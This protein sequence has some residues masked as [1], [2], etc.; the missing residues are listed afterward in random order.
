MESKYFENPNSN[1]KENYILNDI[2]KDIIKIKY[3]FLDEIIRKNKDPNKLMSQVY[4]ICLCFLLQKLDITY[5]KNMISIIYLFLLENISEKDAFS[6]I[7]N[8][9][10]SNNS[11]SKLYLWEERFV[12][13]IEIFFEEQFSENIPRL[14]QYF[15]KLGITCNLYLYDW[16]EGLFTQTLNIK[17][18]SVIFELYLIYG[19]YILIQTSITILKIL[20]EELLD[21]T[22]DEIFKELKRMPF[23]IS[24]MDFFDVFRNYNSIKEK[25]RNNNAANEF[26][27]QSAILFEPE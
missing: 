23:N 4:S 17:I 8:L 1:L 27:V 14:K 26:A 15:Q 2:I 11:L 18:A 6:N 7:Y 22:I 16:I 20:E 9:I 21:L 24:F 10:C 3:L 12:K 13:I 5:N 25:F 19:E